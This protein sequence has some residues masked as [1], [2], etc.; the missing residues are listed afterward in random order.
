MTRFASLSR[1]AAAAVLLALFALV[2]R[3]LWDSA[4]PAPPTVANVGQDYALYLNIV[5]RVRSGEPYEVAAVTEQR[6]QRSAGFP[7]RPFFVVRPPLRA[8]LLAAL[9]D[10]HSA[11]HLLAVLGVCT[12]GCWLLKLTR[13]GEPIPNWL[14]C[15]LGLA[16]GLAPMIIRPAAGMFHEAWAG[17]LI[18][19]SLALRSEKRFAAAVAVGLLVALIREFAMP[20]LLVMA[21]AAA[22]ERR[23]AE[24]LGFATALFASLIALAAH[25]H[26][27]LSLTTTRD[28]ASPGWM[29]IGGW[30]F[31]LST[32]QWNIIVTLVGGW[33]AAALVPL[34]VI[35]AVGRKGATGLRLAA[36]IIGYSLGFLVIGRPENAYWGLVISPLMGLSMGFGAAALADLLRGVNPYRAEYHPPYGTKRPASQ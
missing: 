28:L 31:A 26:L 29:W 21:I 35:G 9:P 1:G 6:R 23:G 8:H 19:V 22:W 32:A 16:A 20:Y 3:G 12:F 13:E 18:A 14:A 25:A 27:V 4:H 5:R 7:L 33:T 10:E 34:A 36:L 17:V 11:D 30:G 24:A 15:A 2:A